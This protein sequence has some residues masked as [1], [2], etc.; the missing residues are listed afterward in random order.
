MI[1]TAAQQFLWNIKKFQCNTPLNFTNIA[2]GSFNKIHGEA[3]R[4]GNG[5]RHGYLVFGDL[6][7]TIIAAGG[8]DR[9]SGAAFGDVRLHGVFINSSVFDHRFAYRHVQRH[10]LHL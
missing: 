4:E 6:A 1:L 5:V 7:Y 3:N 10:S 9:Q 2:D 8:H